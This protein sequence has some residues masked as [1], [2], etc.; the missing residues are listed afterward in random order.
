MRL[1][2]LDIPQP[3]ATLEQYRPH[4]L[5]EVRHGWDLYKDGLIRDIYFRQDRPGV[6]ILVEAE[7][8]ETARA[9]LMEFPLAKVGLIGWDVIPLGPMVNWEMLFAEA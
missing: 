4:L 2:C 1:L 9:Q 8:V 7:S 6:A 3:G 5:A